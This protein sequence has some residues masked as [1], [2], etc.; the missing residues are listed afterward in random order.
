MDYELSWK[1]FNCCGVF[2]G[3]DKLVIPGGGKF[4]FEVYIF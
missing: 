2:P 1:S 3:R 4:G